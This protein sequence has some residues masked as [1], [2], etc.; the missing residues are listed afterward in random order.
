MKLVLWEDIITKIGD[1]NRTTKLTNLKINEPHTDLIVLNTTIH[2]AV[3]EATDKIPP[4]NEKLPELVIKEY[5]LP[6]KSVNL[7]RYFE[8]EKCSNGFTF[9]GEGKLLECP[10]CHNKTLLKFATYYFQAELVIPS[11]D[12]MENIRIFRH[13]FHTYFNMHGRSLPSNEDGVVVSLLSDEMSV[14]L[15]NS[16]NTCIGFKDKR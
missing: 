6:A 8:C 5:F 15:C 4:N 16:Q 2:T 7:E 3:E 11:D 12:R 14:I 13:Q 10:R 9:T 1:V